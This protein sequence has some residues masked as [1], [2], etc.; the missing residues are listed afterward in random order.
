MTAD[1]FSADG[2]QVTVLPPPK[3]L[4]FATG[5]GLF[6]GHVAGDGQGRGY[7]RPPFLWRTV[8]AEPLP[9]GAY[10]DVKL[11][12]ARGS[13]AA[14]FWEIGASGKRG[15]I[16]WRMDGESV[17]LVDLHPTGYVKSYAM[18]CA[19]GV[20]VGTGE[21]KAAKGQKA[22]DVGLI[23]RG[24]ADACSVVRSDAGEVALEQTDGD[25]HV[26]GA[27][28]RAALW[29]GD[30]ES[31]TLLGPENRNSVAHGV[32][33]GE[34]VGE[35]WVGSGPHACLWRGSAESM[36]D[37]TPAGYESSQAWSCAG[38]FQVGF[39]K[40]KETTKAGFGSPETRACLWAGDSDTFLDLHAFV[41]APWNASVA[42]AIEVHSDV[43]RIVGTVEEFIFHGD[44]PSIGARRA[45]LWEARRRG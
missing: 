41:P 20:H 42:T 3:G 16:G 9:L 29:R 23:W 43:V 39:V 22:G 18:G 26:G 44:A 2:F 19:K 36:V 24:S 32:G 6:H 12:R 7:K 13:D 11:R 17:T 31:T 27:G 45:C 40:R 5:V 30:G 15:A 25:A 28:A 33:D 4:S 1:R 14:G 34:Q 38:G 10:K 35:V 21:P 8:K 37:L